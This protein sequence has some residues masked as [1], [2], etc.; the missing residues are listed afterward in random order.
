MRVQYLSLW[1]GE[2]KPW[3]RRV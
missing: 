2:I 3:R 1:A